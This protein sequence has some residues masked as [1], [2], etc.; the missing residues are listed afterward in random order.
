MF[1]RLCNNSYGGKS[2]QIEWVENPLDATWDSYIQIRK[3]KHNKIMWVAATVE[4]QL[5][6]TLLPVSGL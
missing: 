5:T 2:A 3:F 1:A 4:T 6:V